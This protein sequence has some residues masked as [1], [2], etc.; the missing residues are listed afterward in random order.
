MSSKFRSRFEREISEVLTK[1]GVAYEYETRKLVY[2]LPDSNIA[3]VYTPDFSFHKSPIVMEVKGWP[4]KKK[5]RNKYRAVKKQNPEIDLRFIFQDAALKIFGKAGLTFGEWARKYGFKWSNGSIPDS[6][7]SEIQG[8]QEE[9]RSGEFFMM[10]NQ[11]G[12]QR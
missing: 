10:T 12:I 4:F 1:A 7:I 6:W 9:S 2:R 11:G 8:Q 3:H 5:E